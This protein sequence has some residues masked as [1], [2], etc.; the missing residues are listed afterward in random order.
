MPSI[1]TQLASETN[2]LISEKKAELTAGQIRNLFLRFIPLNSTVSTAVFPLIIYVI[3]LMSKDFLFT[4]NT[5][6][7]ALSPLLINGRYVDNNQSC[8]HL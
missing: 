6:S 1:A 8:S 4:E 7:V 5:A 3:A 2:S